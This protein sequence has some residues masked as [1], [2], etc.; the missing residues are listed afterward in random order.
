MTITLN[1]VQFRCGDTGTGFDYLSVPNVSFGVDSIFTNIC[2]CC[3]AQEKGRQIWT[4]FHCAQQYRLEVDENI[5][6]RLVQSYFPTVLTLQF[7]CIFQH[8]T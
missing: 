6:L 5:E 7:E 2:W 4:A 8:W 3:M 1:S